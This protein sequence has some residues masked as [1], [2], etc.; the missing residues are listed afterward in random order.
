MLHVS[1]AVEAGVAHVVEDLARGQVLDGWSVTVA[2]PPG[3]LVDLAHRAGAETVA[4]RASRGPGPGLPGELVRLR[5]LVREVDPDIVHLH[6]SQAGLVGRLA[7][8]RRVPT[9]FTPHAWSWHSMSGRGRSGAVAF[10]RLAARWT[11]RIVAVSQDERRDGEQHGVRATYEVIPNGVGADLVGQLARRDPAELRRKLGVEPDRE[12]VV[13]CGRLAPQKGQDHLLTAWSRLQRA[14]GTRLLVLV[15][16]GPQRAELEA[17]AAGRSDVLFV[18]WQP[19]ETCLRWMRAATLTVCP[20]RY[21][22]MSLVPLE[23]AALGVP[24]LAT[25]VDGMGSELSPAARRLVRPDDADELS[26]AL[27]EMLAD[28]EQL[29]AGAEE[30]AAWSHDQSVDAAARYLEVYRTLLAARRPRRTVRLWRGH[31]PAV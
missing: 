8:R 23:A 26:V 30:A 19:R 16:D 2:C 21:E 29:A 10:E 13:C 15:G 17:R 1:Q 9:V 5:R 22:G 3:E 14:D 12:L 20:S 18:G 27:R 25:R 4:W 31:P 7:L 6:S 11:D 28:P 24:M